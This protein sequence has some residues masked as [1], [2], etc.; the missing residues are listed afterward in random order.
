[1]NSMVIHVYTESCTCCYCCHCCC[2]PFQ[3]ISQDFSWMVVRLVGWLIRYV[4][5]HGGC[6][7][8]TNCHSR[9][10][11]CP[12][13]LDGGQR[14]EKALRRFVRCDTRSPKRIPN[15]QKPFEWTGARFAS[16]G[17]ARSREAQG[18]A[19]KSCFPCAVVA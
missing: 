15:F 5:R 2:G 6:R 13:F 7:G 8:Q 14:F 17:K 16:S 4:G 12:K 3:S 18:H 1:M 9:S 11:D 10:T 19:V